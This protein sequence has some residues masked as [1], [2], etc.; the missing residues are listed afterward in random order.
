M[1]NKP[2][3]RPAIPW[4]KRSIGGV[5]PVDSHDDGGSRVTGV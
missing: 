3:I 2:F 1:V 4:G 5:G